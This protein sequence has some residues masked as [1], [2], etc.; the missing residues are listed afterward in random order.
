L[1]QD[2]QNQFNDAVC[3]YKIKK[4]NYLSAIGSYQ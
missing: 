3:M 1:Y 4:V 2:A